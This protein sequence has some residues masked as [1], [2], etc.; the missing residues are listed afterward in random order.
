M[1]RPFIA[2]HRLAQ[3]MRDS[4]ATRFDGPPRTVVLGDAV[5]ARA[6]HERSLLHVSVLRMSVA[7]AVF[8]IVLFGAQLLRGWVA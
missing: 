4:R 6:T 3:V 1:N 7:I 8:C 5:P 2:P